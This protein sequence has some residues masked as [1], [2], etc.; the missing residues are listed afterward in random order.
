MAEVKL[1]HG[2]AWQVK[3][4]GV[5][6]NV[7]SLGE[8]LSIKANCGPCGCDECYGHWTQINAETGDLMAMWISGTGTEGDPFTVNI[9][10]YDDALV[11]LKALKAARD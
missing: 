1:G 3:D 2:Y 4:R 7:A 5:R 9:D 11:T 6:K 10:K 8:A